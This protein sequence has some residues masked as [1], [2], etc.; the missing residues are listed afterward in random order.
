MIYESLMWKTLILQTLSTSW[1][2]QS[3]GIIVFIVWPN[4]ISIPHNPLSAAA[5]RS[6]SSFF[7]FLLSFFLS[8]FF[9]WQCQTVLAMSFIMQVS[10]TRVFT[11]K[12]MV[13]YSTKWFL[14][15]NHRGTTLVLC[16]T[17]SL[18]HLCQMVLCRTIYC[19]VF[20]QQKWY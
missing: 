19:F 11:L 3:C 20:S 12:Q 1:L 17:I 10:L 16:S 18:K 7:F 4:L 15:H 13:L 5:L 6:F 2:H 9:L 14:A 8:S